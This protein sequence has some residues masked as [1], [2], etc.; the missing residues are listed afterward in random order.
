MGMLHLLNQQV[1]DETSE[2][3]KK[4]PRLRM[5][6]NFHPTLDDKVQRFINCMEV[7]TKVEIHHHKVDEMLLVIKGSI[8]ALLYDD[9]CRV[10]EEQV[11]SPDQGVYGVQLPANIWHTVECLEANTVL[12]EVKEGPFIPHAEGG[13]LK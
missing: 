1:I 13:V 11:I 12:F 8:K 3:A 9:D 6:Y 10:I 4:S 7:G 5:N 2:K